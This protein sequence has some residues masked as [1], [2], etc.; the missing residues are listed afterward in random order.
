MVSSKNLSYDPLQAQ[1]RITN[2]FE[3]LSAKKN[4]QV[5]I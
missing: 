3:D 4:A 1:Y 5:T 2:K